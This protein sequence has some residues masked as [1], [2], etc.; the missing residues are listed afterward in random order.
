[1]SETTTTPSPSKLDAWKGA[2]RH[3]ITLPTGTVV[4]IVLP[5]L[6]KM[7][8]AGD[9]PNSL[10]RVALDQAQGAP[11]SEETIREQFDFYKFLVAA[12]VV[13][14]NLS[15]SDVEDLPFE[16]IEMLVAIASRNRDFDAVG[17][18]IGGL[19]KQSDFR[20]FRGLDERSPFGP[21]L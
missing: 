15:P 21:S 12:T 4:D 20:R 5:N 9:V 7:L 3:T 19:E 11:V 18:H 13:E 8:Q 10:I 2:K 17:H 16:D 1:M 6:P 14:P